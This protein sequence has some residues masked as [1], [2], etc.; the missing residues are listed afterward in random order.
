MAKFQLY[1]NLENLVGEGSGIDLDA[2]TV[3][4]GLRL[5][6]ERFPSLASEL[7]DEQGETNPYYNLL[8]NGQRVE[9]LQGLETEIGQEDEV[10]IFPPIAA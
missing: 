3:A 5:L 1:G 7:L 2:S 6:V 9:F 10:S 8:V 4:E